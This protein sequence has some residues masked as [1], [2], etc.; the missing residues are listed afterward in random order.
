MQPYQAM[1][2]EWTCSAT[3]TTDDEAK[4]C[5]CPERGEGGIPCSRFVLADA[6]RTCW[7]RRGLRAAGRRYSAVAGP[8]ESCGG[9]G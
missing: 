3:A 7:Q 2:F 6:S 8:S 1:N 4:Q 9:G 5:W